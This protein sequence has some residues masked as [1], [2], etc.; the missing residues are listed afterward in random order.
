MNNLSMQDL[1]QRMESL[2]EDS[3]D[4][5]C[6]LQEKEQALMEIDQDYSMKSCGYSMKQKPNTSSS[7]MLLDCSH[8]TQEQI[9]EPSSGRWLSA[10]MGSHI[11]FLT[12]STSEFHKEGEGSLLSDVLEIQGEHLRKYWLSP[13]AASGILVRAEKRQKILPKSLIKALRNMIN[14]E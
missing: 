4:K 10:G 12:L 6:L 7:K 8:Q 2:Q 1:I 13:K 5:T 9:W 14:Q 11:G 3:P